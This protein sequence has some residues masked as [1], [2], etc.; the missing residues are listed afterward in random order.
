MWLTAL[1]LIRSP[2]FKYIAVAGAV[3]TVVSYIYMEGKSSATEARDMKEQQEYVD[4]TKRIQNA[5]RSTDRD[6]ALD[7]LR[8]MGDLR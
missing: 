6:S 2:F 3:L 4:T 5:P 7:L 8:S 1:A